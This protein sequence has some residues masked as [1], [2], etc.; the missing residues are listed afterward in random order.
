MSDDNSWALIFLIPFA[1][2]LFFWLRGL[3]ED[4]QMK[5][6]GYRRRYFARHQS[7]LEPDPE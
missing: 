6:R 1:L 4:A 7:Y 5:S 3:L 2:Y